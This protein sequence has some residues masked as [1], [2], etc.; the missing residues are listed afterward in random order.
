MDYANGKIYKLVSNSIPDIYIGSTASELKKRKSNHKAHYNAWKLGNQHYITSFKLFEAGVVDIVLIEAF[1][2]KNKDE[3]HARERHW[4]DSLDCV[5]NKC[6]TR[7]EEE[8]LEL[9]KKYYIDNKE[10]IDEC[11]KKWATNNTEKIKIHQ[12]KY[13]D[14]HKAQESDR[15]KKYREEH[16]VDIALRRSEKILC[17]ICDKPYANSYMATHKKREHSQ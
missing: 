11:N 2:C 3:L 5:N 13:R 14:T 8:S 17:D 9:K 16:K 1:P 4:I 7:T 6:P 12:K 15:Y 10:R